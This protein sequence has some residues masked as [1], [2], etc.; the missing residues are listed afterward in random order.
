VRSVGEVEP[1]HSVEDAGMSVQDEGGAA[2]VM[3]TAIEHRDAGAS[4]CS[5]AATGRDRARCRG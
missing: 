2:D 3:E 1:L 5:G 4:I